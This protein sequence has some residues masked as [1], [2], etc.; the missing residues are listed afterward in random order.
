M[1]NPSQHQNKAK[2]NREFLDTFD[3]DKHPDWATVV[4]FY[5]AV[6][7]VERLRALDGQDSE[8][9]QDRLRYVQLSHREIHYEFHELLNASKLAR[10]EANSVFHNQL[11]NDQI[12]NIVIGKWLVA[13]EKYVDKYVADR[14]AAVPSAKTPPAKPAPPKKK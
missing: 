9:H 2:N 3:W 13:I 8:N 11:S 14:T 5:T 12:I 7:L 6:H 4:A 1:P 10:Y